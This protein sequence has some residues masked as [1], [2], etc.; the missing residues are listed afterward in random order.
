MGAIEAPK[1]FNGDPLKLVCH[2]QMALWQQSGQPTPP[3]TLLRGRW[4]I[5]LTS[6]FVLT[7]TGQPSHALIENYHASFLA[8]FKPIY[9]LVPNNRYVKLVIHGVPCEHH[10]NS[11]LPTSTKLYQ[12]LSNH[13]HLCSCDML[14]YPNW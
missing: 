8:P 3:L 5:G 2:M 9:Q 4:S 14:D 11:T 10:P 6:N 7:F 13:T 12:Q 1:P